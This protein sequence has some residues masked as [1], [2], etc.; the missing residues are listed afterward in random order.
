MKLPYN[1]NWVHSILTWYSELL[2]IQ[3]YVYAEFV[4][5]ISL[6][7][8]IG[9]KWHKM[10]PWVRVKFREKEVEFP[11]VK[12]IF[13]CFWKEDLW[14]V[15]QHHYRLSYLRSTH[16]F[17]WLNQTGKAACYRSTHFV[18]GIVSWTICYLTY[19]MGELN[20]KI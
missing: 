5:F 11:F 14:R 9:I 2:P 20:K 3:N 13:S 19:K 15:I 18:R 10:A 4:Q 8:I 16:L 6:I 1:K 7:S 12:D 17:I